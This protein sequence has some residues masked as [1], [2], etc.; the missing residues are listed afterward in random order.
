MTIPELWEFL[1][2]IDWQVFGVTLLY[3]NE[4]TTVTNSL[5]PG[6]RWVDIERR[7]RI[8]RTG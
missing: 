2:T 8:I 7:E 6:P 5:T 3:Q 1:T 4:E